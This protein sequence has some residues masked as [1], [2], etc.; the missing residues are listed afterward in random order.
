MPRKGGHISVSETGC[1]GICDPNILP[2]FLMYLVPVAFGSF[3][4]L[5][6][7]SGFPRLVSLGFPLAPLSCFLLLLGGSIRLYCPAPVQGT[8]PSREAPK[9]AR[10]ALFVQCRSQEWASLGG[11]RPRHM[12]APS[13]TLLHPSNATH[14][15]VPLTFATS[16]G[17]CAQH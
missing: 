1:R 15:S 9:G 6:R 14:T 13:E 2:H 11:T 4:L 7:V 16:A 3:S 8:H 12:P 5:W 17:V 10:A